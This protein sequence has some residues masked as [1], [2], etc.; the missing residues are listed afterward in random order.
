MTNEQLNKIGYIVT[1]NYKS[2]ASI[3][4]KLNYRDYLCE[5]GK[6]ETTTPHGIGDRMFIK[7]IE[8][9]IY[10]K[11]GKPEAISEKEYKN[12]EEAE[13]ENY[14]WAGE[15]TTEWQVWSWGVNGNNPAYSG[16]SFDNAEDAD[17]YFFERCEWYISEKNWEAP[18]FYDTEE[19]AENSIIEMLAEAE[20]L[21]KKVAASIYAKSK[22]VA[23]MRA[24]L[25]KIHRQKVTADYQK[26]KKWLEIAVP[27]EAGSIIIDE[28]FKNEVKKANNLRSKEKSKAITIAFN[29]LLCRQNI[30]EIKSDFW[31][32]LRIIKSRLQ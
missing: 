11:K 26:R 30:P 6:D 24:E 8:G 1:T 22:K 19:E 9:S 16:Y 32:V 31:E 29:Q 5:Y 21:D 28:E 2:D 23:A 12:M 25:D 18:I 10:T 20:N 15:L 3:I 13:Q 17:L 14:K 7:E 27:A 4:E